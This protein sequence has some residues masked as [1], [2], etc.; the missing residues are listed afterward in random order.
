MGLRL[1]FGVHRIRPLPALAP[2]LVHPRRELV[3]DA[4][5]QGHLFKGVPGV[6]GAAAFGTDTE[7]HA[8]TIGNRRRTMSDIDPAD[9]DSGAR[10][11][12]LY[13][14]TNDEADCRTVLAAVLPAHDKRVRAEAL[15][16]A[17]AHLR[18][19]H[20]CDYAARCLAAW[21][22]DEEGK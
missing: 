3:L 4:V 18:N 8:V 6:D 17:A 16:E 14:I 15:R 19:V 9:V 10:A 11:L 2:V 7:V 22:D 12:R 21:A 20:D 5:L 13:R 1:D